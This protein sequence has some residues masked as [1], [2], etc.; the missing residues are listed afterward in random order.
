MHSSMERIQWLDSLRGLA[1]L[2]VAV[3]HLFMGSIDAPFR[4]YWTEPAADNRHF[5]QLPPISIIFAA[6]SM[7]ALFM[8]LSG[9]SISISLVQI[10]YECNIS[11]FH[12]KLASAAFR[13][14]FRLYIPVFIMA[15]VAQVALY[16]DFYHW[17]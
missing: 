11:Q 9:Y 15:T 6:K 17:W 2:I 12:R 14:M 8:V 10:R 16:L 3:D 5:Y 13:R 7:V 1:A 4:S